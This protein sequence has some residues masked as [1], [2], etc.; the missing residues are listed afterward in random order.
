MSTVKSHRPFQ[1]ELK[2]FINR[3][4]S[5]NEKFLHTEFSCFN[6]IW[7]FQPYKDF[8]RACIKSEGVFENTMLRN[9]VIMTS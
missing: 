6:H 4:I 8:F 9:D 2:R 5:L 3:K 7:T 1:S